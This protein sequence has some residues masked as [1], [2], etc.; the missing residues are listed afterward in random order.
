MW[1][2][3]VYLTGSRDRI[4]ILNVIGFFVDGDTN[5]ELRRFFDDELLTEWA[6][7]WSEPI[8]AIDEIASIKLK[9]HYESMLQDQA[10]VLNSIA[11]HLNVTKD[12]KWI[13]LAV[14]GSSF[15][16]TT[17]RKEGDERPLE[18]ARKG[19]A[20]DWQNYFTRRDAELFT[21]LTGDLL[22]Q[23]GYEHGSEWIE[24]CPNEL[25]LVRPES[26]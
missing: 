14:E 11:E 9:V 4:L 25:N 19:I 3:A 24:S 6:R 7:Y 17:G 18:K 16:K 15:A 26:T 12:S 1:Q 5:I 13:Q 22:Q 23:L 10:A 21:Q 8:R 2:P 20:G